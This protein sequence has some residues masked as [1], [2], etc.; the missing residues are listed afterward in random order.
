MTA[1]NGF[2][3]YVRDQ[4]APWAA[5]A[6]RRM[7]GGS[8]LFR[9]A[10]MFGLIHG[11]TLYFRTDSRNEGDF[12]AA[13]MAPFRY[14]RAGK[15]VALAYHEVPADLLDDGELLAGWAD[16]AYGAALARAAVRT[17]KSPKTAR[18]DRAWRTRPT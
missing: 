1:D 11:D 17:Q 12:A 4:L 3:D 14:N 10:T 7:F 5:V 2:S 15:T 18:E 6:V 8:G 16:K 13:G 9:G